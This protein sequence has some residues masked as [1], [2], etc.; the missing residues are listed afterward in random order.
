MTKRSFGIPRTR[1]TDG[2]TADTVLSSFSFRSAGTVS[3]YQSTRKSEEAWPCEKQ[4]AS[5]QC[6]RERRKF[7]QQLNMPTEYW[8]NSSLER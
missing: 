8:T 2:A 1:E 3:P 6:L 7:F 4:F 5:C